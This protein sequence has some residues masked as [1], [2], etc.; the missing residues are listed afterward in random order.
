MRFLGPSVTI[1]RE[2]KRRSC[3]CLVSGTFHHC[4]GDWLPFYYNILAPL[5]QDSIFPIKF[6]FYESFYIIQMWKD[7]IVLI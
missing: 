3:P 6:L 5:F 2:W 7:K 4:S 1:V